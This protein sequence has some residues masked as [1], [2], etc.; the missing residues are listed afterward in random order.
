MLSSSQFIPIRLY[1]LFV[2]FCFYT[3]IYSSS[4]LSTKN[5]V[6]SEPLVFIS[7]GCHVTENRGQINLLCFSLVILL[8]VI[9]VSTISPV[10]DKENIL[11]FLPYTC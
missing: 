11:P 5:T 2:E 1:P 8:F 3:A 6:F 7:E 9:E 10:T 4:N